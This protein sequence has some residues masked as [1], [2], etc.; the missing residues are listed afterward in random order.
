MPEDVFEGPIQRNKGYI[1]RFK[2][3][4]WEKIKARGGNID[5]PQDGGKICSIFGGGG[6]VGRFINFFNTKILSP[7]VLA[8]VHYSSPETLVAVKAVSCSFNQ[9]RV[10]T[11]AAIRI[12]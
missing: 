7:A 1:N 11:T 12:C 5:L 10:G 6:E 4:K 9:L 2:N 8:R 3:A